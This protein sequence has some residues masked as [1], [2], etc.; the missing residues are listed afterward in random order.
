VQLTFEDGTVP[1]AVGLLNV[2][3]AVS[4]VV[5]GGC[6]T[7]MV[8]DVKATSVMVSVQLEPGQPGA[9]GIGLTGGLVVTANGVLPFLISLAGMLVEPVSVTAAGFWPGGLLTPDGLV[10][11]AVGF[12]VALI[13]TST[14]PFPRPASAPDILRV[15]PLSVKVWLPLRCTE[16]AAA[17][18]TPTSSASTAVP[19]AVR[20]ARITRTLR[21]FLS[22][23]F[24]EDFVREATTGEMSTS[25]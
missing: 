18:R 16:L 7:V 3:V 9:P 20:N 10:Q 5:P 21:I 12:P 25:R 2:Q 17:G 23:L 6:S 1:F 22:F 24:Q 14:S 15:S 4:T 8:T 13:L 11:V 19:R